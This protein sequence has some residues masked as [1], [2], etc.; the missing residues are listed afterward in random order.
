MHVSPD[1]GEWSANRLH[2]ISKGAW[3]VETASTLN[4]DVG[5]AKFSNYN[6]IYLYMTYMSGKCC[7]F[8][9]ETVNK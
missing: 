3:C 2:I 6:N 8:D 1:R 4:I 5:E 7:V 9:D